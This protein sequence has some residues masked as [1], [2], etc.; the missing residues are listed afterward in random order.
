MIRETQE[1]IEKDRQYV[2]HAMSGYSP[3]AAAMVAVE[4]EGA[5]F[6][7]LDGNRYLDGT[8]GL[9]CINV[10]YGREELARAAYDQLVKLP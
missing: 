8:S 2:W 6:T 10:G 4:G 5:W 1:W 3:D 7:A 9:W